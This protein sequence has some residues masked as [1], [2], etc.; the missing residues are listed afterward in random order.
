[1]ATL[2]RTSFVTVLYSQ[3]LL[4]G[5]GW[6]GAVQILSTVPTLDGV[7]LGAGESN[8]GSEFGSLYTRLVRRRPLPL[9]GRAQF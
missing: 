3:S 2:C 8:K 7:L 9:A 1:M 6:R 5:P 4:F